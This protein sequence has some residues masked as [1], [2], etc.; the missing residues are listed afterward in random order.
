MVTYTPN[1]GIPMPAVDSVLDEDLWGDE[2]NDGMDII[3][4]AIKSVSDATTGKAPL[5]S[6]TFTGIPAAP[7]A[8]AGT[9][10]TQIATTAFVTTAVA[11]ATGR[12]LQFQESMIATTDSTTNAF[13]MDNTIPQNTEGKEFTTKAIT[14]LSASSV[15]EIEVE[16]TFSHNSSGEI[17]TALFVDAVADALTGSVKTSRSGNGAQQM[18]TYSYITRIASGSTS[19]RTY[20]L[21]FGPASNVGG[22]SYINSQAGNALFGG[23]M[24]SG[25]RITEI[26]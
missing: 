14:P 11:A 10:T 25:I 3:D 18:G 8:I 16:V 12:I 20:K 6:P 21:R 23:A 5:A 2:L 1:Y 26:L 19:A 24:L 17:V 22:T 13:P 9:N 15:L 4:S 7:T